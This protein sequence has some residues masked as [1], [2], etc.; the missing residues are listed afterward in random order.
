MASRHLDTK[1]ISIKPTLYVKR[2][3]KHL[4]LHFYDTQYIHFISVHI[5][6]QIV[7][8]L[9]VIALCVDAFF[10]IKLAVQ[11]GKGDK[12]SSNGSASGFANKA[13]H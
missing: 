4:K 10:A 6:L 1:V 11:Y 13:Y 9:I 8:S 3:I 2:K 12:G 7:A 5:E